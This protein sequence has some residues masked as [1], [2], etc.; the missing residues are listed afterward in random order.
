MEQS[1]KKFSLK[2]SIGGFFSRLISK[3]LDWYRPSGLAKAI[4][5]IGWFLG[6]AFWPLKWI[7]ERTFDRLRFDV[8][9]KVV[10]LIFLTPAILGF[11]VFFLYPMIMSFIYSLSTI[12]LSSEGVIIHFGK[13]FT[14]AD[15]NAH[16]YDNPLQGVNVFYNYVYAFTVDADYP[17]QLWNT[18]VGMISDCAV[19]TIFSLLIAVM[20]NGKFRGRALVRAIFFLPVI[21]NSEAVSAAMESAKNISTAMSQGGANALT[22]LFDISNFLLGLGVPKAVITF[23][24]GITTSIYDTISYSGIQILIFLTAIQSVP[25]HLYEAAKMEGAT[26][27][28]QFWKITLPMVSSMIPTVIVY[29]VVDS[30]LRS[31][32][33]KVIEQFSKDS[34]YGIHAAM[35]WT[36]LGVVAVFLLIVLGI[37]SK[38]VFYYDEKK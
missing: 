24:S 23:L 33:N 2:S 31:K 8:Q 10:A 34:E 25:R 32:V 35:S 38:V 37:L 15:K 18:F 4:Q 7:K 17:V 21:F 26:Q 28:E 11:L 19:I 9:K 12:Q 29:T 5:K 22:G 1:T 16:I 27:Y 13:F 6:Y 30:F 3:F 14:T 36:Y 20:L